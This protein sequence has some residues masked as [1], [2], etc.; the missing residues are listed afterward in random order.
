M[1]FEKWIICRKMDTKRCKHPVHIVD[2]PLGKAWRLALGNLA[3]QAEQIESR[4]DDQKK[5]RVSGTR[6]H[7]MSWFIYFQP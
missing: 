6:K 1:R 3:Q 4:S 7:F 2:V 5:A